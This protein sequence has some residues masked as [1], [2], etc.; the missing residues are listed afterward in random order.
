MLINNA[1]VIQ[2]GPVDHM[3]L[4]DFEAA[5]A[6]HFRGPLH[7]ML[8]G[9]PICATPARRAHRQHL[10]HRRQGRVPHLRPYA[11]SKF[12]LTVSRPPSHGAAR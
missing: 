3:T 10:V 4:A 9:I 7:T 5:M 8:A 2:V 1:G 11:A 12:A 6:I